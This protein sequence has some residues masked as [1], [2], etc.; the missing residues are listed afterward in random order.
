MPIPPSR[1][2]ISP[3]FFKKP[4]MCTL[5]FN[6]Y[7]ILTKIIYKEKEKSLTNE[8]ISGKN[9][10]KSPIIFVFAF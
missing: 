8:I 10:K 7:F 6:Y 1:I 9:V 2:K 5:F 3:R 4:F